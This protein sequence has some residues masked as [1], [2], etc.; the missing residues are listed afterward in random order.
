MTTQELNMAKAEAFAGR[1]FAGTLEALDLINV[2][3]GDRLGLY[4]SLA[5]DGPATPAQLAQRCSINERYA[6]EW[7][8]QQAVTGIV[9]VDDATKPEDQRTYTLPAHH[10]IALTDPDS[11]FSMTPLARA[12]VSVVQA[13]PKVL[14]A[15][16]TGG[17]VSWGDYGIDGI[18]SQG[19]FNR[20][21][22]VGQFATEYI[23]SVPDVHA[24]LEADPPARVADFACGV[25]WASIA[26]AR[27]YPK[28]SVDGFD[29][30]APS[31]DRARR[32]AKE[33]G[34]DNRAS[35]HVQDIAEGSL[36]G[37]YDLVVVIE[38]IHDLSRPVE[39][40]ANIKGL[41]AP[42]GSAIIAD[43]RTADTFTAP[44][45]ELERLFYGVSTVI[46]LPGG[47]AEQPS[48]GTGTV[49]RESTMRRY[50]SEAGFSGVNILDIDHFALRF[51][52]LLP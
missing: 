25:G 16:R 40:L 21:W 50:A 31:I 13:L 44:G 19:D 49:M 1:L 26:L 35:F 15:Y 8:E 14:E 46:C 51:Y 28:I 47:M 2:Y 6:R 23:P 45:D 33:S 42:G 17:G 52:H 32:F 4:R 29:F 48:A 5:A 43:E 9:D 18:E 41:L 7:L 3:V 11:P 39:T 22:L 27:A 30:D 12:M 20:P 37:S 38:A 24:R 36:A 34:V 10:G